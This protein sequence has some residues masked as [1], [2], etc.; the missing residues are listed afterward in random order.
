MKENNSTPKEKRKYSTPEITEIKIDKEISL[1][2]M[3]LNPGEDP[4]GE[5]SMPDHFNLN[6]FKM[7]KL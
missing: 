4:P 6:P 7:F 3:S 2:M 1:V 5:G